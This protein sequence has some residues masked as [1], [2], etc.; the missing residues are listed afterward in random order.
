MN[1][2]FTDAI[3]ALHVDT[4]FRTWQE[5]DYWLDIVPATEIPHI[6]VY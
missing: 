5:L 6:E 1:K 2:R 4:L 3:M